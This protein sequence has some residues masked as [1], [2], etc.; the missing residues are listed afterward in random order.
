MF[1]QQQREQVL[2]ERFHLSGHTVRFR[3]TIQELEVFLV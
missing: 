2:I 1:D 3:W